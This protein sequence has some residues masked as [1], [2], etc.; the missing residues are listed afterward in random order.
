MSRLYRH[1]LEKLR[2]LCGQKGPPSRGGKGPFDLLIRF[3]TLSLEKKS[4]GKKRVSPF[5]GAYVPKQ[6]TKA[7]T[8]V[9]AYYGQHRTSKKEVENI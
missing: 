2:N 8:V 3:A 7:I 9:A 6:V 4:Y 5:S 1:P